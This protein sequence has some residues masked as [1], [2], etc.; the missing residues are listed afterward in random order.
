MEGA[1]RAPPTAEH[2]LG[3]RLLAKAS[4]L[5]I[6]FFEVSAFHDQLERAKPP[7]HA[8]NRFY[9][10]AMHGFEVGIQALSIAAMF[11]LVSPWLSLTLPIVLVPQIRLAVVAL[12]ILG[13]EEIPIR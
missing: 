5:Q 11:A 3:H 13:R 1:V 7:G 4:R 10:A 12:A 6:V 9:F 8:I 2:A